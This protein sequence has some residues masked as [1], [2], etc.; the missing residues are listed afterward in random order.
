VPELVLVTVVAAASLVATLLGAPNAVPVAG[1]GVCGALAGGA[2]ARTARIEGARRQASLRDGLTGLP[3]S[4]GMHKD[5]G[6]FL[7]RAAG[8]SLMLVIF[9]LVGFKKYNDAYGFACG[10]ALLRRLCDKLVDAVGERGRVYRLR[11]AQF[12]VLSGMAAEAVNELSHEG[13]QALFE[14]GEGF[15]IRCAHGV[16]SLPDEAGSVSEALKLADQRVQSERNTL[17]HQGFDEIGHVSAEPGAARVS[18]PRYGVTALA[19]PTGRRLGLDE[20]QL[21]TLR[22]A[23]R[24]RD[25]GMMSIPDAIVHA[26]GQLSQQEWDFVH[27]HT[28]VGERIL[29]SNFGMDAVAE[30]VRSSHERFDGKG[31]PHGLVGDAIPPASRI[32]FVCSAFQDMTSERAHRPA[33]AAE[34]ALAELQRCAGS[35]F[36]PDVVRAFVEEFQRHAADSQEPPLK[37]ARS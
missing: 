18:A 2:L 29:R 21:E 36:D 34:E 5:V 12:C 20:D 27:L 1:L 10:D 4:K 15:M 31:Y 26:P 25:V 28:L 22:S 8:A 37:M 33:L 9:D 23:A 17:Q 16:V 14:V 30:I 3:N 13:A 24:L 32:V 19:V 35:Q 6:S 11:G 7:E